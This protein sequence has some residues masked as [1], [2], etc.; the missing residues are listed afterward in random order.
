MGFWDWWWKVLTGHNHVGER[1]ETDWMARLRETPFNDPA[2]YGPKESVFM[3]PELEKATAPVWVIG[4][5]TGV[6]IHQL[7]SSETFIHS[8]G[9]LAKRFDFVDAWFPGSYKQSTIAEHQQ[10]FDH[11]LKGVD[12]G[13]MD[14]PPVRVQLRTGNGTHRVLHEQEWPIARTVYRR[15]Y[16]DA[17]PTDWTGDVHR[18]DLLR[19]VEEPPTAEQSAEY[20]A[21][22]DRGKPIPAPI[23]YVGGTP[24]WSTGVSFVSDPLTE[25]LTLAGYMKAGLW[26]SSTSTDMDVFVSLRVID[27]H[28]R[29]IRYESVVL[30][31]DPAHV[32][33]VGHGLLKVSRRALDPERTTEYWPVPT[34]A[35]TDSQPLVPGEVVHVEVGLYP[36]TALVAAGSRLRIDIQPYT[37]SGIPVREYDESYHA[38]ATNTVCTGPDHPSY[39]QLPVIPPA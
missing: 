35:E 19:I 8:T 31:I 23:G 15:W 32:H 39:I 17:S 24:R 36:S 21:H 20:D 9:A 14:A 30:P 29:E 5:Q 28:D 12:N 1:R 2:A 6:T 10:F 26:V 38:G 18:S 25:D 37:P 34:H 11:W 33:P 16:L 7:G 13:V 22:L 27:E 4:P 3:H